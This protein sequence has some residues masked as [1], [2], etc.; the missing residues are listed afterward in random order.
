MTSSSRLELNN[1][2][3]KNVRLED[4]IS[5]KEKEISDLLK[6]NDRH[7]EGERKIFQNN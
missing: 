6:R 2:R 4:E 7:V 5:S 3:E 1:E